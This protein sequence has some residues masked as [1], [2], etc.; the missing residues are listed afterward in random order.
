MKWDGVVRSIVGG[1]DF[2]CAL[3]VNGSDK[4]WGG[5][6]GY[7]LTGRTGLASGL[8]SVA[9][10]S[11]Q[12]CFLL[13]TGGVQCWGYIADGQI[14]DASFD[15]AGLP[16][17]AS[18]LTSGV[19]AIS[20]GYH[21]SCALLITGQVKCWGANGWGQL[22][23]SDLDGFYSSNAPVPVLG[24]SSR[25]VAITSGDLHTC[26]LLD[27]GGVQCWGANVNGVTLGVGDAFVGSSSIPLD[28]YGL[29]SGVTAISSRNDSTCALL[30]TGGVKCW[31][32]YT[33]DQFPPCV[34]CG[35]TPFPTE[36]SGLTGGV[37]S[38]GSG[39][40][41]H[42]ALLST[43]DVRCW[44]LNESGQLGVKGSTRSKPGAVPVNVLSS[45]V[46]SLAVGYNF[47]CALLKTGN[48][49]CWGDG[50]LGELGNGVDRNYG[51][52]A[53]NVSGISGNGGSAISG[54]TV[55]ATPGGATCT[56]AI[57]PP[58]IDPVLGC[59]IDGLIPGDTYTFTVTATN[60]VGTS[61]PSAPSD[62]ITIS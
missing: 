23:N 31:G 33:T 18:G 29:S 36:V 4:C 59:A 46:E 38:L 20:S 57:V 49:N 11:L 19:K 13:D 15:N 21:F 9:D 24:L 27:T 60:A 43:G 8:A 10:G 34:I 39:E 7:D 6:F 16:T 5:P 28:V 52:M 50:S 54:Y 32:V 2:T 30:N 12:T 35:G 40:Y 58:A 51:E 44:G 47:A 56:T 25:A 61:L 26:A 14:G 41:H 55:T 45:S 3:Y 37:S 17:L 22:G 42:C 1:R 53:V 62:P 48:V